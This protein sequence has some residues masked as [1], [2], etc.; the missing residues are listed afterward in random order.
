MKNF[1]F[2]SLLL[3]T[4]CK[5]KAQFTA[6]RSSSLHLGAGVVIGVVGGYSANKIFNGD[7]KWTWAGAV[8]SALVAGMVK[9][10]IDEAN[11]GRWDINDIIFTAIG[12]AI[13]GLALELLQN[14]KS[15]RPC[16]CYAANYTPAQIY[17]NSTIDIASMKSHSLAS[18]IRANDILKN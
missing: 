2:C 16:N 7:K 13:S 14:R 15:S 10:S 6:D 1:V 11:Y 17:L 3:L 5:V 4:F 8:G 18:N 12:G 9:E